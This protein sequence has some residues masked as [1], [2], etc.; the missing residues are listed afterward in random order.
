MNVRE[1]LKLKDTALYT[2]SPNAP[3]ADAIALM[4]ENDVG[5]VVVID[6]GNVVGM[7]TF[8][9]VIAILARRLKERYTGPTPPILEIFV[10]EAM[11]ANPPSATP[12]MDVDELRRLM[13]D[14]KARYVPVM[15]GKTVICVISLRDIAKAV[16]EERTLENKVLKAYIKD[17]PEKE[18]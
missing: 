18:D 3:I 5:A 13:L 11:Y 16:L 15:D 10:H 4:D 12:D 7:L 17:W 6:G 14:S 8:K 2:V 1:I 9:E